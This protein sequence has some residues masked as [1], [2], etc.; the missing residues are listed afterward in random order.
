[1]KTIFLDK[2]IERLNLLN[3][4][5]DLSEYGKLTLIE[6]KEIKQALSI[7]SVSKSVNCE[8]PFAYVMSKCNGEINKCLQCGENL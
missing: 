2:E 1:M 5:G 7:S 6:F 3:R 8:H 4:T